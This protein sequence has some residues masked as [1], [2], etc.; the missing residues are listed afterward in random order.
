MAPYLPDITLW[1]R[2]AYI[3]MS[4]ISGKQWDAVKMCERTAIQLRTHT[5]NLTPAMAAT[6]A[7]DFEFLILMILVGYP[8]K[9]IIDMRELLRIHLLGRGLLVQRLYSSNC[10]D[11]SDEIG[12]F[13]TLP[14]ELMT[15]IA[16]LAHS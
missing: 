13:H 3:E 16:D 2:I 1:H 12:I 9:E 6:M 11:D 4:Y 7:E 5:T 14:K 15:H 10:S 8:F